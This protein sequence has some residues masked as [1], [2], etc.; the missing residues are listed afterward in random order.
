MT[1]I[2]DEFRRI[3]LPFLIV[4]GVVLL[5]LLVALMVGR[6]FDDYR[7]NRR[8]RLLAR[9]RPLVDALLMPNAPDD[10]ADQLA[11]YVRKHGA[12]LA[13]LLTGPAR[14]AS[15]SVIDQL[16]ETAAALGLVEQW[17]KALTNR[18]W[19]LRAE[20]ARALGQLGEPSVLA[21]LVA[22]LDDEH[23]EV[24][25]AGVEALGNI[26]DPRAV[27]DLVS[28]LS[29]Q[30]RHQR[31]RVVEA[32]HRFGR[33]AVP[34]LLAYEQIHPSDRA[35]VAELLGVIGAPEAVDDLVRWCEDE[36]PPVRIAAM[37]ALG[38]IGLDERTYYYALRG[39]RSDPE[40]DVRAMAA[41]ALGRSGRRETASY[42]ARHLKDEWIVA[43]HAA[44]GLRALGA[45]GVAALRSHA[46]DEGTA[47][48]LARQIL[49][50]MGTEIT[51]SE[52]VAS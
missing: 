31:V 49:F 13:R 23:E 5:L 15:G 30:S 36:R 9:I 41:R 37:Q 52:A 22:T 43:A 3:L 40:P 17:T 28:K 16:R 25:A 45:S 7:Y 11:R 38:S 1:Y 51:P 10:I 6:A 42:L 34:S 29:S 44:T 32:L 2:A 19:W 20:A 33:A 14:F 48:D 18:R 21:A 24:R 4:A 12:L 8:Q 46:T 47:G 26:G 50:E 27:P 39:L 35:M